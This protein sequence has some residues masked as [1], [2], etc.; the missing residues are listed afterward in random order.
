MPTRPIFRAGVSLAAAA[1]LAAVGC[2]DDRTLA[3]E[4]SAAPRA[5]RLALNA[6]VLQAAS[7]LDARLYYLRTGGRTVDLTTRRIDL[8]SGTQAVSLTVDPAPCLADA[9]RLRGESENGCVLGAMLTLVN[10]AGAAVDSTAVLPVEA[11]PGD[12]RTIADDLTLGGEWSS[13]SVGAFSACAIRRG[14]T[15]YCWGSNE[16]GQLGADVAMATAPV[17]VNAPVRFVRVSVGA[18]T[19]CG[20]T[21]LGQAYCWGVDEFGALGRGARA[22]ERCTTTAGTLAIG[23]IEGVVACSRAVQP[24]AGNLTLRAISVGGVHACGLDAA[25]RA[26]CWGP[27]A[28]LGAG[29]VSESAAVLPTPVAGGRAYASLSTGALH[30]CAVTGAGEAYCWG[31]NEAGEIGGGASFTPRFAPVPT[32]VAG[33]LA[34]RAVSAGAY[35]TCGVT[36]SDE[37]YCWGSNEY[38]QQGVESR[39]VDAAPHPTPRRV[40]LSQPAASIAVGYKSTC[41]VTRAGAAFCWGSAARGALGAGNAATQSCTVDGGTFACAPLPVP[42]A[43]GLALASVGT[44]FEHACATVRGSGAA[45]CWG[46]DAF[47]QLG[48]RRTPGAS[49]AVPVPVAAP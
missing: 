23:R 32:P 38:L 22:P 49:S 21:A 40:A 46:D 11:T 19:A 2:F 44:G 35:T 7:R 20:L 31:T 10:A 42:V 17:R 33:G 43:G 26:V 8:A 13:L 15:T 6:Q 45:Y 29:G 34:F 14:G 47:G 24:V 5:V 28:L 4:P 16:G 25:S 9:E 48:A 30:A 39:T 3:P 37:A 41:A 12:T 1:L 27:D 18:L 36:R